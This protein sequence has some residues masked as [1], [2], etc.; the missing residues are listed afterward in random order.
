MLSSTIAAADSSEFSPADVADGGG[1]QKKVQIESCEL[2][3][4]LGQS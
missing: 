2:G 1:K 3:I 4:I